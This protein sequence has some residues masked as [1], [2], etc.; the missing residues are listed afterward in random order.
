MKKYLM[1]NLFVFLITFSLSAQTAKKPASIKIGGDIPHP[2]ELTMVDMQGYQQTEVSRKGKDGKVYTYTGVT[3]TALLQKAGSPSGKELRGKNLKKYVLISASDGYQVV[4]ALAETDKDFTDNNIILA[5]TA[6]GK[7]LDA[8][9]GPFM[10]I[11]PDEK[12]PARC[13]RQVVEIK[14]ETAN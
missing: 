1:L 11:T 9:E 8:K 12:I 14:V 4:F 13:I 5:I 3:L 7:P 6:D 2:F 10:I